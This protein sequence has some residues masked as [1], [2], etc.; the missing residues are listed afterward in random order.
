MSPFDQFKVNLQVARDYL[1]IY[2]EMRQLKKLGTRGKLNATNQH[3]LWLPRAAVVTSLGALDAY[4]H[5]VLYAKVPSILGD[6]S[7]QLSDSLCNLVIEVFPVKKTSDV[8]NALSIIRSSTGPLD[9][10]ER[11]RHEKLGFEAMQST[12]K[13]ITAYM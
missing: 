6:P 13:I 12:D 8:R 5:Q 9:V 1:V 3:L 10:A 7:S 11:I 2:R 4:V